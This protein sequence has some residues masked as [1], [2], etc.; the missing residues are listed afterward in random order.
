[1]S[2]RRMKP[3]K[4]YQMLYIG[5]PF[6]TFMVGGSYFLSIFMDTHMQV[7]DKTHGTAIST[8]TFNLQKEHDELLKKLSI[9]DFQL[10]R[11]PRPEDSKTNANAPEKRK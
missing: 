2:Y 11:I 5:V 7:K 1:M 4:S 9:D 10:S 3:R 6:I 8:R